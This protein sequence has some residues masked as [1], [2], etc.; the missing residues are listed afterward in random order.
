MSTF[1]KYLLLQVPGWVLW[2]LILVGADAWLALPR[3][4]GLLLLSLAIG[5][6]FALYPY[7]RSAYESEV[8]TGAARLLGARARVCQVLN[9]QGYVRVNGELWRAELEHAK[10]RRP[11]LF[12]PVGRRVVVQGF[13]GLTLVVGPEESVPEKSPAAAETGR[14]CERAC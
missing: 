10:E 8:K 4:A 1:R 2:G 5:K 7:V 3:W 6:D 9:P 14:G 12:L 13:R 11:A